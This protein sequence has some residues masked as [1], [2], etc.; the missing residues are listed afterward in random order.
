MK[1]VPVN[2]LRSLALEALSRAGVPDAHAKI[3]ADL[4]IEGELRGLPSHGLLRLRRVIERIQAGL[5][6]P[7]AKGAHSWAARN[8]LNV[9]GE[10]GLGPVI[11]MEALDAIISRAREDGIAIAAIHNANH[12]GALAYYVEYAARQDI[13][14]IGL[15]ISEAL[16]HPYG[17]RKA[18]IGTNPIAIGV[19]ADP[20]PLILDMATSLVAMGKIYDYASKGLPIPLGWA[21]DKNGD[22]TTDAEAAKSGAIAPFGGPKGYALGVAIE[23]L[24]ASLTASAIGNK[25]RGTLDST[26]PSNKGDVFIAIS[27]PQASL[28]RDIVNAYLEEL[29][30][31]DPATVGNPVLAPGDRARSSRE[32]FLANGL[33]IDEKLHTDLQQ[34]ATA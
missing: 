18:L 5:S 1:R 25:V 15:T 8:Y 28:A 3:Q 21:L 6:A 30:Q 7:G 27:A 32:S 19:P 9:D 13:T 12:L 11:A 23:V 34:M 33:D 4:L 31:T 20:A 26:H 24:V 17:G 10:R 22:P 14:C 16:V 2:E 29:R